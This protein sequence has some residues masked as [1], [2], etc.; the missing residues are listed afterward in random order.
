MANCPHCQAPSISGA[1][2]WL[3]SPAYPAQ[4][5]ACGAG[6]FVPAST[7]GTAVIGACIVLT[8]SGFAAVRFQAAWLFALGALAAFALYVAVWRR[9][10]LVATSLRHSHTAKRVGLAANL[11]VIASYFL[12]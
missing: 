10:K 6:S 1:E 7:S 8:L 12:R 2:K 11:A 5:K 3:A 9:V 4:C